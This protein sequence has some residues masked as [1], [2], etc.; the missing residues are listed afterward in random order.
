M[1]G[2]LTMSTEPLLEFALDLKRR[3]PWLDAKAGSFWLASG[4]LGGECRF[5]DCLTKALP[6]DFTGEGPAAAF[7]VL[8]DGG[9]VRISA[10]AIRKARELLLVF[11]DDPFTTYLTDDQPLV[12]E[13]LSR[14]DESR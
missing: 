3:K 2:V 6:N 8:L 1:P 4:L 11:A 7:E 10:T 14:R 5:R 9:T 13:A 12:D